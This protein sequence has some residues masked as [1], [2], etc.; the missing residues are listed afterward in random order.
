MESDRSMTKP[1]LASRRPAPSL[2]REGEYLKA[3]GYTDIV[4]EPD[5]NAPPDLLIDGGIAV[6]VRILNDHDDH[7]THPQPLENVTIPLNRLVR[8]L[9]A[10]FGPPVNESSWWVSYYFR[11]PLPAW[12]ALR[13]GVRDALDDFTAAQPRS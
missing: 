11:R 8:K 9:L 13:V 1:P 5:G 6:E 3:L 12:R 7:P 4:Y 10:Q 2:R